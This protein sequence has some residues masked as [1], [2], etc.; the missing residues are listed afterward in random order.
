[1]RARWAAG[2]LRRAAGAGDGAGGSSLAARAVFARGF[3]DFK[4]D[5]SKVE[6]KEKDKARL[7]DEMSRSYFADISE[8]R[9][10]AGKLAKA[11]KILIPEIAAV[12]FPGLSVEFPD[13][14]ALNLP[15]V[16]TPQ[17]NDPQDG[18]AVDAQ[19]D[20]RKAGDMA[21]PDASLVCL[22]FRASSQNMAESWSQPFLDAFS[23]AGNIQVYEPTPPGYPPGGDYPVMALG[24]GN[25]VSFIDSWLFSS[26]PLKGLFIK[27]MRKSNNP[28]RNIV[29]SFGDH[30]YFR[31]GL[32]I[33]NLLTGYIYL[34]DRLGRVRWQG[35]GSATQEE[36]SSLTACTSILLD[37]K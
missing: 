34:V 33:R 31:K 26:S 5:P 14:R 18:N 25:L 3:F 37:K 28:Q 12:K 21:V 10:N 9:D 17:N 29:Y 19:N 11:N 7:K 30:Y 4:V 35:F 8:I 20:D 1:M 36:L 32:N 27:M 24:R 6:K 16:A 2:M 23:S 22:S 15:L 13:G